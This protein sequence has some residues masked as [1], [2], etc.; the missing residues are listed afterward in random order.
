MC[1]L[2]H[3]SDLKISAKKRDFGVRIPEVEAV[4]EVLAEREGAEELID[5]LRPL[6]GDG[7]GND[8]IET[9]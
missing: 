5:A 6:R 7:P 8:E 3:R 9:N 1:I 2:L 4:V